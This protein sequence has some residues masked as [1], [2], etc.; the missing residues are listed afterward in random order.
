[1]SGSKEEVLFSICDDRRGGDVAEII[2]LMPSFAE[3]YADRRTLLQYSTCVPRSFPDPVHLQRQARIAALIATKIE[4]LFGLESGVRLPAVVAG[5]GF[6]CNIV[7]H[8][9]LMS[10]PTQLSVPIIA[11]LADILSGRVGS[12]IFG[13]STSAV[14]LEEPFNRRSIMFRGHRINLYPARRRNDVVYW[15]G[16][17]EIDIARRAIETGVWRKFSARDQDFIVSISEEVKALDYGGCR[18]LS[19]QITIANRQ[20][21]PRLFTSGL[22]HQIPQLVQLDFEDV[23]AGYLA[24][25]VES[26]PDSLPARMLLDPRLRE[27]V[28]TVFDGLVGG[29]NSKTGAGSH[30]FWGRHNCR[31]VRLTM[32]GETVHRADTTQ[33]EKISA[34]LIADKLRTREWMP[35]QILTFSALIFYAG[36]K[37]VMGWSREFVA[38]MKAALAALDDFIGAE[39]ARRLGSIPLDNMCLFSVLKTDPSDPFSTDLSAYDIMAD[40]GLRRSYLESA[41][42]V[43]LSRWLEPI[44][45]ATLRYAIEKY[46][47]SQTTGTL[48]PAPHAPVAREGER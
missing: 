3:T 10:N 40:G 42:D 21:F 43:E 31:R 7:D 26:E 5:E 33:V 41:G 22:R 39:E 25:L 14:G 28:L 12:D 34:E 20:L 18:G 47:C 32:R 19:D 13:F 46:G 48:S 29:W 17:C 16:K 11:H 30:F 15:A 9:K 8:Q 44:I 4:R 45:P 35:G 27:R 23:A 24:H 38:R 6:A 1:M 36:I 2:R 37:P